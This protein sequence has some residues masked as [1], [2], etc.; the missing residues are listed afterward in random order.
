MRKESDFTASAQA[1][2][3]KLSETLSEVKFLHKKLTD[4]NSLKATA[5]ELIRDKKETISSQIEEAFTVS[6]SGSV[7][8]YGR[9]KV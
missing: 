9:R 5:S 7:L 2:L 8:R 1:V 3:D 6:L 4:Q